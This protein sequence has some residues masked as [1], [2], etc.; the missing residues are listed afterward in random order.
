MK[1]TTVF[2]SNKFM[3][4]FKYTYTQ[5]IPYWWILLLEDEKKTVVMGVSFSN[6]NEITELAG[7]DGLTISPAFLKKL[8][9]SNAELP[10]KS[11]YKG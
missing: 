11:E 7:C 6:T 3:H 2:T 5:T 1:F 9:E 4:P 10:R 8:Q